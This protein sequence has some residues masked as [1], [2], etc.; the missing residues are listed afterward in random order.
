MS[1]PGVALR[2]WPEQHRERRD[3]LQSRGE[4]VRQSRGVRQSRD[5]LRGLRERRLRRGQRSRGG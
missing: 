1:A 3:A 4:E 2:L 5:V